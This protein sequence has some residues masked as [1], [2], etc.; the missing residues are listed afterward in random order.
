MLVLIVGVGTKLVEERGGFG[1][2]VAFVVGE[3]FQLSVEPALSCSPVVV[4]RLAAGVGEIE[5]DYTGVFR[6]LFASKHPEVLE[7]MDHAGHRRWPVP[8]PDPTARPP[9]DAFGVGSLN[10]ELFIE[11][12]TTTLSVD[13]LLSAIESQLHAML[14]KARLGLP[15]ES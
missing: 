4:E 2:G 14:S 15:P 3:G 10:G 1:E 9:L 5:D 8:H 11:V 6:I 13:L 12:F 7:G